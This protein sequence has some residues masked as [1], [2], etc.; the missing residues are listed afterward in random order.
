[1]TSVAIDP[2]THVEM[3]IRP[4][5]NGVRHVHLTALDELIEKCARHA[6]VAEHGVPIVVSDQQVFGAGTDSEGFA[7]I[8]IATATMMIAVPEKR[9]EWT[10]L[11]TFSPFAACGKM[12]RTSPSNRH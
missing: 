6:V 5:N 4:K 10:N 8:P 12:E 7:L 1:M 9:S 3:T 11:M 2:V